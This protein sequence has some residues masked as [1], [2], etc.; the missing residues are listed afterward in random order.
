M[1]ALT[2]VPLEVTH[3]YIMVKKWF[4]TQVRVLPSIIPLRFDD[5]KVTFSHTHQAFFAKQILRLFCD[6]KKENS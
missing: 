3:M 5:M 4:Y 6:L 1:S 2:L